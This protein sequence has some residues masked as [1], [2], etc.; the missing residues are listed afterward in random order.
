M[1]VLDSSSQSRSCGSEADN[2]K[3]QVKEMKHF[4]KI[5]WYICLCV[6][7]YLCDVMKKLGNRW[8]FILPLAALTKPMSI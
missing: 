4:V 8:G 7:E 1:T 3:E 6:L 2:S 5:K